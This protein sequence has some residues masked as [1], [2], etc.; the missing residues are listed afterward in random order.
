MSQSNS[1]RRRFLRSYLLVASAPLLLIA[2]VTGVLGSVWLREAAEKTQHEVAL[3]VGAE[4][5][6]YLEG[7]AAKLFMLD[8]HFD[9]REIDPAALSRVF[10]QS[11]A[12][13][14]VFETIALIEPDGRISVFSDR[15]SFRP[16]AS[17][18]TDAMLSLIRKTAIN[19]RPAFGNF[20]IVAATGRRQLVYSYPIID[21][22]TGEIKRSLVAVVRG[23]A[24]WRI[25]RETPTAEGRDVYVVDPSGRLIAHRNSTFV[26]QGR[27][28]EAPRT[29][30][31]RR[32]LAG[33]LAVTAAQPVTV[34]GAS[35]I[36]VAEEALW[37]ALTPAVRL[38]SVI[39]LLLLVGIA[40][41]FHL[42]Y[43]NNRRIV[44][45]IGRISA[46]AQRVGD[47]DLSARAGLRGKDEIS[48]LGQ[49]FDGMTAKVEK[50]LAQ[51]DQQYRDLEAKNREIKYQSLHDAL[52]G[53]PNRRYADMHLEI[54]EQWA[55]RSERDFA[56]I[57]MDL[58]K[59][60]EINDTVGHSAG[61]FV[62]TYAAGILGREASQVERPFRIGGDEFIVVINEIRSHHQVEA[63]A[64]RILSAIRRPVTFEGHTFRVGASLGV[65]F[66][67]EVGHDARATLINADIALYRAKKDGRNRVAYF[68]PDLQEQITA[69][70]ALSDQLVGALEREEFFPVFQPQFCARS[71]EFRGVEV[72]CRWRHPERGVL[73][74][75]AFLDCA[76]EMKVL[77]QIDSQIFKK[78]AAALRRLRAEGVH[79]PKIS[80]NVTSERLLQADLL[81]DLLTHIDGD[82]QVA[83]ELLESM[84]LDSLSDNMAEVI[85]ELRRNN[86][87]IE[88]DDFGSCR[89]SIVG[90]IAVSPHALKIDRQIVGP[91]TESD[92]HRH[93]VQ[94]I[95][96]IGEALSIKVV[97]EGVETMAHVDVLRDLGCSILQGYALAR[98]MTPE[99][100]P[101]FLA[102]RSAD[103]L[104]AACG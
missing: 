83:I 48:R 46:T 95:I 50:L 20:Q 93:L 101:A 65:A 19:K 12:E 90:L 79:V 69:K 17:F 39:F 85:Q 40:I 74:P 72:L 31:I 97:A 53:L 25:L 14:D 15:E 77:G 87:Q 34:N 68:T 51:T 49:V 55:R 54:V 6:H 41:A 11:I 76:Q 59:F 5:S 84:S 63:I 44:D 60:K 58:D 91:I 94:A 56:I 1:I 28:L 80:F 66:G 42:S 89:A 9:L 92:Q 73:A 26:L 103:E 52:T 96:E 13:T 61:D 2:V 7:A 86:I 32:G 18:I 29:S 27:R 99:Q 78:S 67:R 62:L 33:G 30:G 24:L 36:I 37:E 45:P 35:Y 102:E 71:L 3:R 43:R 23:E 75:G 16:S 10:S 98:P 47:G 70:K 104:L 57:H 8:K 4:I 21:L 100:L 64:Q 22:H 81:Q 38:I 88:I 82:V